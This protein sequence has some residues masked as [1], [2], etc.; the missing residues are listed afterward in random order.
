MT[1]EQACSSNVQS[2]DSSTLT[3]KRQQDGQPAADSQTAEEGAAGTD[4]SAS[5][6]VRD[7]RTSQQSKRGQADGQQPAGTQS[8]VVVASQSEVKTAPLTA[9]AEESVEDSSAIV[10]IMRKASQ[11]PQPDSQQDR[12]PARKD[13]QPQGSENSMPA[14]NFI[15]RRPTADQP[16]SSHAEQDEQEQLKKVSMMLSQPT[17]RSKAYL[18]LF[19]C[20]P[21]AM[22]A[23]GKFIN[24]FDQS[25]SGVLSA[26][27]SG[28]AGEGGSHDS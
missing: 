2:P 14:T 20:Q 16:K 26:I 18:R 12:Q 28:S 11:V 21:N 17:A 6:T 4:G 27:A 9:V 13:P 8:V 25:R 3:A 22:R 24:C 10:M 15:A 1:D 7:S 5:Q 23:L 19:K